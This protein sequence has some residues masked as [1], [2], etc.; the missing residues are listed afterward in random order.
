VK[1]DEQTNQN[2][3]ITSIMPKPSVRTKE[4]NENIVLHLINQII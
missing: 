3:R 1:E 4:A 2:N